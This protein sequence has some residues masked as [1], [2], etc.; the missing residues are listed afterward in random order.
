VVVAVVNTNPDIVRMLRTA[1]EEAGFIV[2]SAHI[3]DI[4]TGAVDL[5]AFL[6]DHDPRVLVY[7]IAPP[8]EQNWRFLE[9]IKATPGFGGRHFVITSV[10]VRLVEEL[11]GP[12]DT[13]YEVVGKRDDIDAI[14]RAVKEAS[15]ARPTR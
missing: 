9:H 13:V 5:Q 6:R 11:I 7:D 15:R 10:N 2:V 12:D 4:K 14:V 3:E 8:Y 1:I